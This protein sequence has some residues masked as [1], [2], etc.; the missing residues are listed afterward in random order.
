MMKNS[1]FGHFFIFVQNYDFYV[2]RYF[3][4]I[5]IIGQN[6]DFWQK[7][8]LLVKILIFN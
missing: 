5:S 3:T 4:Q 2:F 1:L 6:F 8:R 7:V